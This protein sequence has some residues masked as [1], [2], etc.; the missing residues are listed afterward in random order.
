[1]L[2][3]VV[4]SKDGRG[5]CWRVAM[6]ETSGPVLFGGV[7]PI[8]FISRLLKFRH[9]FGKFGAVSSIAGEFGGR[10]GCRKGGIYMKEPGKM[11]AISYVAEW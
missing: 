9:D 10:Q 6:E 2:S 3:A 8:F 5:K 7:G 11:T 4:Q 1:M